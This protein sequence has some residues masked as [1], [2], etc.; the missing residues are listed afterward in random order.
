M[1]R[2]LPGLLLVL[3]AVVA[4]G[5]DTA[6][7]RFP[8]A[9]TSVAVNRKDGRL[10]VLQGDRLDVVQPEGSAVAIAAVPGKNPRLLQFC[11][12]NILYVTHDVKGLPQ[13]F[14]VITADGRERLAWPNEGLAPFFPSETSRL[15]VDG[16]GV[17]GFLTL[18]PPAREFFGLP[19]SVPLG[20]GV[21]ATYRFAGEKMA[22]RG[23]ELFAGVVALSPD[24]MLLTVK[25]GGAMRYRSPGGSAWKREGSGGDWRVADVDPLA[26][27]ALTLDAQGAVRALDLESGDVRWQ[28]PPAAGSKV[29]DALLLHDGKAL[30]Y[31][32][33]SEQPLSVFDPATG[34][35]SGAAVAEAFARRK[36][37]SV[38]GFWLDH[39]DSLAGIAELVAGSGTTLLVR[40]ADGWYEVPL[41]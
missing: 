37:T 12:G 9:D 1:R 32:G 20:A 41:S 29:R 3:G 22:A 2:L 23:S 5:A 15:S 27:L 8:G 33:G 34:R 35:R 24:D 19:E 16:R 38:L 17:Y 30:L 28:L 6:A 4:G 11:G 26:G 7:P 10:A 39:T 18:D 13:V 31:E 36:L 40:G 25:G 21:A 14:V